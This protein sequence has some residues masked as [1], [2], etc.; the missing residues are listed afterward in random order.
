ML[1]RLIIALVPSIPAESQAIASEFPGLTVVFGAAGAGPSV[2]LGVEAWRSFRFDVYAMDSE[3]RRLAD[4]G[5]FD[6]RLEGPGEECVAV[7]I[8]VLGR[9]QRFLPR[10]N[11]ASKDPRFKM[12][13]AIH[14]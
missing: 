14:R 6:L 3:M 9:C 12:L 11:R 8:E 7:A 4:G 10:R 5:P 2:S 13:L 1:E